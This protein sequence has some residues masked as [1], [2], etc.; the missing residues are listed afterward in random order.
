M[1][2]L[3]SFDAT[4]TIAGDCAF[5]PTIIAEQER[6]DADTGQ[7]VVSIDDSLIPDTRFW[8]AMTA[9]ARRTRARLKL[10]GIELFNTKIGDITVKETMNVG[11]FRTADFQT[12]SA[13]F[14]MPSE[15]PLETAFDPCFTVTPTASH[16]TPLAWGNKLTEIFVGFAAGFAINEYQIFRGLTFQK[17]NAGQ[18]SVK[19][20]FTSVDDG[21]AYAKVP[22]CYEVMPFSGMRRGDVVRGLAAQLGIPP[23]KVFCPL[24]GRINKPIL[25]SNGSLL[26]FIAEFGAGEDWFPS[27]DREGNLVVKA[28]ELKD[29]PDWILDSSKGDIYYDTFQERLPASPP[30][31]YYVTSSQVVPPGTEDDEITSVILESIIQLYAPQSVKVRPSG[32]L[33]YLY[34]DGTYRSIPTQR[35]MMVARRETASTTRNGIPI[36][37]RIRT[38]QF[39]NEQAFDPNFTSFPSPFNYDNAYANKTFHKDEV[40]SLKLV[41]E[42]MTEWD[43][44]PF[45]TVQK[46]TARTRGFYSPQHALEYFYLNS[47]QRGQI[48]NREGEAYVYPGSIMRSEKFQLSREIKRTETSYSYGTE[49]TIEDTIETTFEWMSPQSR[50]DISVVNDVPKPSVPPIPIPPPPAPPPPTPTPQPPPIHTSWA[51]VVIGPTRILDFYFWWDI[52]C[53]SAPAPTT[54]TAAVDGIAPMAH[55][56]SRGLGVTQGDIFNNQLADVPLGTFLN[57]ATLVPSGLRKLKKVLQF[58]MPNI[59]RPIGLQYCFFTVQA[60]VSAPAAEIGVV[61]SQEFRWDPWAGI[62]DGF[63][64]QG[65]KVR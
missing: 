23:S 28:I 37:N 11:D 13:L 2:I 16:R 51:P 32:V 53:S 7:P 20:Q 35:R 52:D 17:Q 65:V 33:T 26:P 58:A 48:A 14:G 6:G 41:S 12:L 60:N 25:L 64:F 44:D 40:E 5:T 57:G 45:G 24:G 54:L 15:D 47:P 61:E 43:V 1:S 59:A 49:G 63:N 3:A 9:Q 36:R 55:G 31:N 8:D 39:Y 19:G 56:D 38:E 46:Q 27:F 50:C 30:S 42:E 21:L 18:F 29:E 34:G 62:P 10:L 22:L 4:V